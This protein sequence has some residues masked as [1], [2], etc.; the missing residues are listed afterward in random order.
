MEKK[1][2]VIGC[3]GLV[4]KKIIEMLRK[5]EPKYAIYIGRYTL[6]KC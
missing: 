2:L 6:K 4:G 3:T 5:D 1:I